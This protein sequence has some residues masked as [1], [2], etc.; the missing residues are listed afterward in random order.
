M[1]G[2]SLSKLLCD[3]QILG[4]S[5]VYSD[6]FGLFNHRGCDGPYLFREVLTGFLNHLTCNDVLEKFNL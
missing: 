2:R 5:E 6:S 3:V 1:S 4:V